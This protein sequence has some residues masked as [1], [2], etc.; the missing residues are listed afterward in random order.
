VNAL[1]ELETEAPY[2][3]RFTFEI[4]G[5]GSER[6]KA[7]EEKYDWEN[8]AHGLVVL[9]SDGTVLAKIPGHR[10]GRDEIV[11]ALDGAMK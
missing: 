11:A 7:S 9:A 3:D 2:K 1:G 5:M 6:G 10:Y 4:V 8:E